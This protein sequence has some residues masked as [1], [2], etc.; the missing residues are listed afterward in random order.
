MFSNVGERSFKEVSLYI[1]R[2]PIKNWIIRLCIM[3]E[4]G[5]HFSHKLDRLH[6]FFLNDDISDETCSMCG[7]SIRG[8]GYECWERRNCDTYMHKSCGELPQ[9][10]DHSLHP[11]HQ[12]LTLLNIRSSSNATTTTTCYYCD[13]TFQSHER[14][15][16]ACNQFSLY[17]HTSCALIPVL[18]TIKFQGDQ[19]NDVA[20]YV[21]YEHP[22]ILVGEDSRRKC[23]A[24]CCVCQS[25]W[26]GPAY[27]C[28]STTC[29]NFLHKWCAERPRKIQHISFPFTPPS[30]ASSK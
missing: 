22:M 21:C 19:E 4:N 23:Q 14:W 12:P 5:Y 15:A 18:P 20:R 3:D 6:Y 10:I 7:L 28:T 17:M 13:E 27:S 8:I 26:S 16:Y 1:N 24:N 25:R 11:L 29:Q 30:R 2:S 9:H